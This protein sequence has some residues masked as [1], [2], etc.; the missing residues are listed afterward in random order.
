MRTYMYPPNWHTYHYYQLH[1]KAINIHETISAQIWVQWAIQT[2]QQILVQRAIQTKQ[3]TLPF[4]MVKYLAQGHKYRSHGQSWV[5][6]PHS[7]NSA[8]RTQIWCTKPLSHSTQFFNPNHLRPP[9]THT[10]ISQT[11]CNK[12]CQLEQ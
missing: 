4:F 7:N 3:Q 10:G 12:I 5:S 1:T 2:K 8:T 6:N 9:P 11:Q